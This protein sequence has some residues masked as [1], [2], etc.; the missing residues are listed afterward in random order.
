MSENQK[1]Q[2]RGVP[3]GGQYAENSHDEAPSALSGADL[4]QRG[5]ALLFGKHVKAVAAEQKPGGDRADQWWDQQFAIGEYEGKDSEASFPKMP[6]DNT[7]S[8]LSGRDIA[9][10]SLSGKLRTYRRRYKG[11]NGI[12]VQ[13]PSATSIKRY[14]DSIS[15]GTF[16]VPV[17]V[18][19]PDG[20]TV[21]GW[22]RVTRHGKDSWSTSA[23]GFADT[24]EVNVAESV[25]AVLEARSPRSSL[26][27]IQNFAA[28]RAERAA[29]A[30]VPFE[31]IER[32][33]FITGLSYV[34][35]SGVAAVRIG[36]RTYGYS[37]VD[38]ETYLRLRSAPNL[39]SAYNSMLKQNPNVSASFP[40]P[41][42]EKCGNM[43]PPKAVHKCPDKHSKA[44]IGLGQD[45]NNAARQRAAATHGRK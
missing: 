35:G 18:T 36:N 38:P 32:S 6:D 34:P 5:R 2:P 19:R 21:D 30:G 26:R 31:K 12:E 16:D 41:S 8:A 28:R 43:Y 7:P 23:L 44:S 25:A 40:I 22:V 20:S 3:V 42:C 13:M 45:Y 11:E 27:G 29:S 39:G 37:N 14:S 17:S 33:S 15:D 10:K 9:G 24:D 4:N 1:R